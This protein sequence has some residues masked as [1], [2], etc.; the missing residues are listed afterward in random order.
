[1]VI[2]IKTEDNCNSIRLGMSKSPMRPRSCEGPVPFG[3]IFLKKI[4]SRDWGGGKVN[5]RF[6]FVGGGGQSRPETPMWTP[7]IN[8]TYIYIY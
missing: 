3:G 7:L 8:C 2:L 6:N 5:P 4:G 1:M